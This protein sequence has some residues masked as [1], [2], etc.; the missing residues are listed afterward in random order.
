MRKES[1]LLFL[2]LKL[3]HGVLSETLFLLEASRPEKQ[4]LGEACCCLFRDM[5]LA[6]SSEVQS[7]LQA[8]AHQDWSTEELFVLLE[9][10]TSRLLLTAIRPTKDDFKNMELLMCMRH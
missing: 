10:P 6:P 8:L 7:L 9:C 5:A 1:R 2:A 4:P 3:T